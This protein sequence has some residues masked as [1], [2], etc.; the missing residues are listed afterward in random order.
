MSFKSLVS[1][2]WQNQTLIAFR[3]AAN[4][5]IAAVPIFTVVGGAIWIK[6]LF[7]RFTAAEASGSTFAITAA[8]IAMQNAAV[9]CNGAINSIATWPLGAAAGQVIVPAL[10]SQPPYSLANALLGQVGQGQ[11]CSVGNIVLTIVGFI[12]DGL[13]E[14][15]LVYQRMSPASSV[16]IP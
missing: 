5:Q 16:T 10:L 7:C 8:G 3:R 15:T 2:V 9:N 1:Q 12:T 14:F 6:A 11:I 13:P 4:Y